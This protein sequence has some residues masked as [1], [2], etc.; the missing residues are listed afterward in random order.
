MSDK[1]QPEQQKKRKKQP[2][3]VVP[4]DEGLLSKLKDQ[5]LVVRLN[6]IEGL[7]EKRD[8]ACKQNRLYCFK[9]NY[10]GPLTALRFEQ[11]AREYPVSLY[12]KSLGVRRD[13]LA[14]VKMLRGLNQKIFLT[15]DRKDNFLDAQL[16]SSLGI[17]VGMFRGEKKVDWEKMNDLMTSFV[18]GKAKHAPVEPFNFVLT[19]YNP[20]EITSYSTVYFDNPQKYLHMDKDGNIAFTH[21][22]MVKGEFFATIDELDKIFENKKFEDRMNAWQESFISGDETANWAGWRLAEGNVTE[23]DKKDES[24]KQFFED[25]LEAAEFFV[26][27]QESKPRK[28]E[29]WQP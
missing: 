1:K 13:F 23:E 6:Q 24:C 21:A 2:V 29:A 15:T 17:S 4:F 14:M 25:L 12:V 27:Q 16:A 26:K 19:H 9:V 18:Y 28:V 3:L 5:T 22:E 8:I 20:R 11:D 7:K 10:N